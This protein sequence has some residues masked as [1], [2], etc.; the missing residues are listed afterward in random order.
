M[1]E[2]TYFEKT[3]PAVSAETAAAATTTDEIKWEEIGSDVE[4]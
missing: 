3:Q 1:V 2:T 4:L